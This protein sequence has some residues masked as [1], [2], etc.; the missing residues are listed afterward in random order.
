[1]NDTF[2]YCRG[3]A[4]AGSRGYPQDEQH[5]RETEKMRETSLDRAK[6][7]RE[8]DRKRERE[9]MTRRGVQSLAE[10][11]NALFFAIDFIP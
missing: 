8:R 1:M 5:W 3:P 2:Q 6:P 11:G 9:R 4:L 7:A 10:S